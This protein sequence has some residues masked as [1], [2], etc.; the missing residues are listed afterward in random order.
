MIRLLIYK[1]LFFESGILHTKI[2]IGYNT[3][4]DDFQK[5]KK[6]HFLKVR[7]HYENH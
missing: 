3:S 2:I 4:K 7:Q 5:F 1:F 6:I